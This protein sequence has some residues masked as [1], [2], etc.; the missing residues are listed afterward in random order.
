MKI[1]LAGCVNLSQSQVGLKVFS[2]K[3]P[4]KKFRNDTTRYFSLFWLGFREIW[5]GFGPLQKNSANMSTFVGRKVGSPAFVGKEQLSSTVHPGHLRSRTFISMA[6]SRFSPD[7]WLRSCI[8]TL[9]VRVCPLSRGGCLPHGRALAELVRVFPVSGRGKDGDFDFKSQFL[10]SHVV[11]V[12]KF[13]RM[14]M[15]CP[16]TLWNRKQQS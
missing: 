5:E 7:V 15:P 10:V 14:S 3:I 16:L 11:W 4:P 9:R 2:Q 8:G 13:L 12:D 1:R 6:A